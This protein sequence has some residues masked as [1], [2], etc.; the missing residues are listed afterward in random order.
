MIAT[1]ASHSLLAL[2]AFGESDP[3]GW[4]KRRPDGQRADQPAGNYV[5]K[6]VVGVSYN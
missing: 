4:P 6:V 3:A 1:A 5:L 2:L